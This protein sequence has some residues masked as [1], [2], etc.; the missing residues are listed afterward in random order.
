MR[1]GILTLPLYTNYGGILQAYALQTILQRMGH[2][3]KVIQKSRRNLDEINPGILAYIKAFI[4][5]IVL[6]RNVSLRVQQNRMQ[7]AENRIAEEKIVCQNTWKF[8]EKYVKLREIDG[9]RQLHENEFDAIIVGSD[10]I[11]SP[12]NAFLGFAS[13]WKIKR[14][15]YAASFGIDN[16]DFKRSET[17]EMKRLLSLFNAVSVRE[18]SGLNM[19]SRYLNYPF[20]VT[21][22]DPTLLLKKDDYESLIVCSP[23][24]ENVL[25]TYILDESVEKNIL[26]EHIA[27]AKRLVVLKTNAK[28]DDSDCQLEERIQPPLEGWLAAF[29]DA[30]F[31][32][33]DSF[34]ACVFSVLFQ[35]QFLVIG[36]Q[37]RGMARF[38]ALLKHFGLE[39]HLVLFPEAYNIEKYRTIDYTAI[40][41]KLQKLRERGMKF[42]NDNLN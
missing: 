21:M 6:G 3:V 8:V 29:R 1:I 32:I 19:C 16:W 15:S 36:N 41:D 26:I 14:L 18:P 34:H 13:D 35:K 2:D 17:R 42:L 22:P 5:R 23:I 31:V 33:T 39:D 24:R 30:D 9:F 38:L 11:S 25:H 27:K 4:S 28:T 40:D 20:A 37:Q 7:C 12:A 10:Q